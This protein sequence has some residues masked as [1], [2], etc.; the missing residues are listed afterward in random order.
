MACSSSKKADSSSITQGLS[1][2]VTEIKGNQMPMVGAEKP[3]PKGLQTIVYVY[4]PTHISQVSRN[5]S[6]PTIYTTIK[7]KLVA[8]VNT[9]ST[10][11]YKI[12]LPAGN[13][14]VFVKL[15]NGYFANL[16]DTENNIS[17]FK[18]EEGKLTKANITV[19]NKASF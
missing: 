15:G 6:S 18:V 4:E 14:S 19:N 7:T 10:G 11:A 13:Y 12:S 9:D 8:S 5:A 17:L 1:G 3:S 16:F 2:R